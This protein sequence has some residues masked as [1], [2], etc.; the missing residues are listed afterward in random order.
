MY[1]GNNKQ[2]R[3]AFRSQD[4]DSQDKEKKTEWLLC[5]IKCASKRYKAK[6]LGLEL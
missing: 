1:A 3:T 4:K 6:V 5:Q 2:R